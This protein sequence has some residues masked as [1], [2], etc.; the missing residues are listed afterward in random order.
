M[1]LESKYKPINLDDLDYNQ[2]ITDKLYKLSKHDNF[3]HMIF[4]GPSGAGKKTRI[5]AFLREFYGK[6]IDHIKIDRRNFKT[7]SNKPIELRTLQ[8]NHHI[9]INPSD[10]G[11]YDEIVVQ[12][13]IKEIA[14]YRSLEDKF[15]VVLI[16]EADK[17]SHKAQHGLRA[18]IEK[19]SE[20]CKIIMSVE[21]ISKI[22][23]PI[24]SRCSVIRVPSPTKS[25]VC[26]IL[27]NVA[28][29]ENIEMDTQLI[30]N[31]ANKTDRNLRRAVLI[32]EALVKISTINSE[33]DSKIVLHESMPIPEPDWEK[34]IDD[35]AFII[36]T[37]PE[38]KTLL[39]ARKKIYELLSNCIPTT[40]VFKRLC[41][42]FIIDANDKDD[43]KRSIIYWCAH[44]EA[45]STKGQKSIY[46][47]E[48]FISKIMVLFI[49][50]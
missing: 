48:A 6:S 7:R 44:Y 8:S 2:D 4:C 31:I 13:I 24:L 27:S 36:I 42:L 45:L 47:L 25:E 32:L 49:T 39:E 20:Y 40:I 10:V 14:Q 29:K 3:P 41:Y 22:I 23:D 19:Y 50:K 11:I 35:L 15:K 26:A 5:M 12:E 9:E 17:L 18:T 16:T 37:K 43:L 34:Y 33:P 1:F 38:P 28:E 30:V 46:F 21:S